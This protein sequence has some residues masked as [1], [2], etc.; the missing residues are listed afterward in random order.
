MSNTYYDNPAQRLFNIIKKAKEVSLSKNSRNAWK[1]I[2]NLSI[3]TYDVNILLSINKVINLITEVNNYFQVNEPDYIEYCQSWMR[4]VLNVLSRSVDLDR[5]WSDI[6]SYLDSHTISSLYSSVKII[7][8]N[9][10]KSQLLFLKK[11]DESELIEINNSIKSVYQ[12]ILISENI[13]DNVKS[14]ILKYLLRLIESIDQYAITGSEAIIE[15]L[16]NTVG[17]MYFNHEYKEFMSNTETGKNLLSKMGEIA[18][19]VTCITG[20]LELANKS[21]ELIENI[22]DFN[23]L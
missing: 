16:E 18:K 20:I 14:S 6:I 3:E 21:F 4:N 5:Q 11:I 7:D 2:L 8:A 22:K 10:E 19:K 13:E 1:E 15:V 23:N 17:H 12:D 9:F